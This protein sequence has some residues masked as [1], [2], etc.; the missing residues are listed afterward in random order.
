ML[1]AK[2]QNI[3]CIVL[4]FIGILMFDHV[5]ASTFE[6]MFID[7]NRLIHKY[8]SFPGCIARSKAQSKGGF[9]DHFHKGQV[10]IA[11]P[12]PESNIRYENLKFYSNSGRPRDSLKQ[13]YI[14]IESEWSV[15]KPRWN[16]RIVIPALEAKDFP[17][18]VPFQTASVL[19]SGFETTSG[20]VETMRGM[21]TII[22]LDLF[23]D[24]MDKWRELSLKAVVQPIDSE[25][26]KSLPRV[27]I[28]LQLPYLKDDIK[29]AFEKLLY[30]EKK[31]N[32]DIC[33]V[34]YKDCA[35]GDCSP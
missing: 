21:P 22:E 3:K 34:Y 8:S 19:I 24:T 31:G 14:E 9:I 7:K 11:I 35:D 4:L 25:N 16:A 12:I 33:N 26:N 30:I 6:S 29:A 1:S 10:Y 13:T 20:D 5:S 17:L 2:Y 32:A 27:H 28:D 15:D 23:R 18:K